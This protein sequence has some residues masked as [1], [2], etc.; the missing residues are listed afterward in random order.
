ME[1]WRERRNYVGSSLFL[2]VSL[3]LH[4]SF[5]HFQWRKLWS[6]KVL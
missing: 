2:S 5:M 1:G 6:Y 4:L 3:S